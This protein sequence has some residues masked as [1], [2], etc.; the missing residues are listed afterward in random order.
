M[1]T[2][3][4]PSLN[5]LE[6]CTAKWFAKNQLA[7]PFIPA[8]H[9]SA[10]FPF[11]ELIDV[12][13]SG[14]L[15][16]EILS[17]ENWP[18]DKFRLWTLSFPARKARMIIGNMKEDEIG[19]LPRY[20]LFP[21]SVQAREFPEIHAPWTSVYSGRISLDKGFGTFLRISS[22]LQ[23]LGED[24]TPVIFGL[25]QRGRSEKENREM[26][27]LKEL[28]GRLKWKKPPVIYLETSSE[29]WM[30]MN[31]VNPVLFNFTT[32]IND[33][34]GVSAAQAQQCGWPLL[35]S[36]WGGNRDIVG[37]N[38][39]KFRLQGGD[40]PAGKEILRVMRNG[41]PEYSVKPSVKGQI[42]NR[43]ELQRLA[44]KF[45]ES[46]IKLYN[47]WPLAVQEKT[48]AVFHGDL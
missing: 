44:L 9:D 32:F 17:Y 3:L 25:L 41:A 15:Y 7:R 2:F 46:G 20:E 36:D 33:D 5:L 35:L 12:V 11:G 38:V 48:R 23:E 10:S 37:K 13:L 47:E 45:S 16:D 28:L 34:F 4:W 27:N 14:R 8:V 26:L 18:G 29:N 30:R 39:R 42:L 6:G 22:E 1:N 40:F 21:V 19:V 24:V 31:L 43:S